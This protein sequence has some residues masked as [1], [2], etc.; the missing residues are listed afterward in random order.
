[1][2]TW[3]LQMRQKYPHLSAAALAEDPHMGVRVVGIALWPRKLITICSVVLS[4]RDKLQIYFLSPSSISGERMP[5][6]HDNMTSNVSLKIVFRVK[7]ARLSAMSSN[8]TTNGHTNGT[9]G[10]NGTHQNPPHAPELHGRDGSNS[11]IPPLDLGPPASS[12]GHTGGANG[13]TGGANG[14]TGGANGHTNG[15]NGTR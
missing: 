14:H 8:H 4:F 11:D 3:I 9:N 6:I 13:H 10:T 7:P 15:A 1:M 5:T 12:D 2:R